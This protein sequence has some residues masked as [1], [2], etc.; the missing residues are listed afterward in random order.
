MRPFF[1]RESQ[2]PVRAYGAVKPVAIVSSLALAA[3]VAI[4]ALCGAIS[5]PSAAQQVINIM[6]VVNNDAISAY[7]VDQRLNL[8]IRSSTLPDTPEARHELAPRVLNALINET[9]ELQEAKRLNIHVPQKDI[10]SALALLEK[11]NNLPKGGLDA[12][13]KA[14]GID[15]QTL[16]HQ[17]RASLAWTDVIRQ[18]FA[19]TVTVTDDEIDKALARIKA[20]ADQ[21]RLLVAEIF[22]AVDTP[23]D[24][25]TARTNAQRIYQELQRGASFPL[26]ARQFSQSSSAER[27]G[28]LGW[29]L[30][31][32][33]DPAVE[34]VLVKMPKNTVTKPIRTP[35]G[36]YIMALR[37]R[38]EPPSKGDTVLS[39][40]QV[41][42]PLPENAGPEAI[43]SQQQLAETIRETVK[44]CADFQSV[45][46]QLGTG[47]SG[48]LGE[49][50]LGEL[51]QKL[52]NV[53]AK[54]N[55]GVPSQPVVGPKSVRVL[56][57]CSRKTPGLQIPDREEVRRRL[58]IQ[59]LTVR[60][61]RYLRDLRDAAFLDIRA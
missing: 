38:R 54:L 60:A 39:L 31:G 13:L 37:D 5:L 43:R 58:F 47:L 50:K 53:V 40:R 4:T 8:I 35:S 3:W 2:V 16:L 15:K 19:S 56:M 6:A 52:H 26:L 55:V 28:D 17:V 21:P 33:L 25:P 14:R 46:K 59:R 32:E 61:R 23:K 48:D 10:D 18:K 57:V 9:L 42:L 29:V 44:G 1:I 51:P 49:L 27:G 7:D 34:K 24:E 30:P 36:Y 45:T 12:F 20:D 11:Q 22:L 41:I